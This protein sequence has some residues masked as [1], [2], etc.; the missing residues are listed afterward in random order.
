MVQSLLDSQ[1]LFERAD[2]AYAETLRL[3][4]WRVAIADATVALVHRWTVVY[5]INVETQR[6]AE[7]AQKHLD[8]AQRIATAWARVKGRE[9]AR[10][11]LEA[12]GLA[13]EC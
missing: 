2:R 10:E 9:K 8:D 7:L 4:I 11:I 6:H 13:P 3:L 5:G 12:T 1:K